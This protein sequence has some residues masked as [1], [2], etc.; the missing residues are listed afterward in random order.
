MTNKYGVFGIDHKTIE[1][2]SLMT[3]QYMF[4]EAW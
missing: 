3:F 2:T 4:Y 1:R